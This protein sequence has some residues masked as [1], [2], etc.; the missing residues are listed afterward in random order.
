LQI[1]YYWLLDVGHNDIPS[2]LTNTD[3]LLQSLPLQDKYTLSYNRRHKAFPGQVVHFLGRKL[4]D[5][6]D[7]FL[8]MFVQW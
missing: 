1:V 6:K 4:E 3:S 5:E 8:H 7:I 2:N